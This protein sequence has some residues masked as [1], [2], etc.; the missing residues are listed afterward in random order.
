M[1]YTIKPNIKLLHYIQ[2]MYKLTRDFEK[3]L[4]AISLQWHDGHTIV[5]WRYIRHDHKPFKLLTD[6]D[7]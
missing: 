5:M 4:D 2:R 7:C 3:Q 1:N 6:N